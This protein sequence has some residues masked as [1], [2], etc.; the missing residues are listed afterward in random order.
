[1]KNSSIHG[2]DSKLNKDIKT[3]LSKDH[4]RAQSQM[5]IPYQN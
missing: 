4:Y 1:M 3:A 5:N 2:L